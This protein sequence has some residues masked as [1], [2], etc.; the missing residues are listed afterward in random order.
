MNG[1]L[2]EQM[3]RSKTAWRLMLVPYAM[4]KNVWLGNAKDERFKANEIDY[5]N[6]ACSA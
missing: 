4:K 1:M 5:G 6:G 2:M 3:G